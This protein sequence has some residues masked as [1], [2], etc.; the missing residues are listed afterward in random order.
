M[1]LLKELFPVELPVVFEVFLGEDERFVVILQKES[2]FIYLFVEADKIAVGKTMGGIIANH[3]IPPVFMLYLQLDAETY[4]LSFIMG[5]PMSSS[6]ISVQAHDKLFCPF[7]H[8]I[9]TITSSLCLVKHL[10]PS[11]PS[12]LC[13]SSPLGEG[14]SLF[15]AR[16]NRKEIE[17]L[18][19]I[20]SYLYPG[21]AGIGVIICKMIGLAIDPEPGKFKNEEERQNFKKLREEIIRSMRFALKLWFKYQEKIKDFKDISID[22]GIQEQLLKVVED[23]HKIIR[24]LAQKHV[25]QEDGLGA[26]RV[27]MIGGII[28]GAQGSIKLSLDVR[29]KYQ[30]AGLAVLLSYATLVMINLCLAREYNYHQKDNNTIRKAFQIALAS[31]E[32]ILVSSPVINRRPQEK[33]AHSRRRTSEIADTASPVEELIV[34][35]ILYTIILKPLSEEL[36]Q[37]SDLKNISTL[38]TRKVFVQLRKVQGSSPIT[39]I[40]KYIQDKEAEVRLHLEQ[41]GLADVSGMDIV[42]LWP[43]KKRLDIVNKRTGNERV[44]DGVGVMFRKDADRM[45]NYKNGD[46]LNDFMRTFNLA[47]EEDL[48]DLLQ[49]TGEKGIEVPYR[50]ESNAL[51]HYYLFP[52][53]SDDKKLHIMSLRIDSLGQVQS[54]KRLDADIFLN[55]ILTKLSGYG[56]EDVKPVAEQIFSYIKREQGDERRWKIGYLEADKVFILIDAAAD[57]KSIFSLMPRN[58]VKVALKDFENRRDY[59]VTS[60]FNLIVKQDAFNK[61]QVYIVSFPFGHDGKGY[62]AALESVSDQNEQAADPGRLGVGREPIDGEKLLPVLSFNVKDDAFLKKPEPVEIERAPEEH[63]EVEISPVDKRP[64]R[65][66]QGQFILRWENDPLLKFF[67]GGN[68]PEDLAIQVDRFGYTSG[69]CIFVDSRE[70]LFL[71]SYQEVR[72][73]KVIQEAV[74]F[75][76]GSGGVVFWFL[77]PDGTKVFPLVGLVLADSKGNLF[78]R[79]E[80]KKIP[81]NLWEW[82]D[83]EIPR[84]KD[85]NNQKLIHWLITGKNKPGKDGIRLKAS[86]HTPSFYAIGGKVIRISSLPAGLAGTEMIKEAIDFGNGVRGV[87]LVGEKDGRPY[88]VSYILFR[89]GTFLNKPEKVGA[90][91]VKREGGK[92]KEDKSIEHSKEDTDAAGKKTKPTNDE[93]RKERLALI[94]K[95]HRKLILEPREEI[96][97]DFEDDDFE[98][99]SE[100]NSHGWTIGSSPLNILFVVKNIERDTIMKRFVQAHYPATSHLL[101]GDEKAETAASALGESPLIAKEIEQFIG[102]YAKALKE[103]NLNEFLKKTLEPVK[104]RDIQGIQIVFKSLA[105]VLTRLKEERGLNIKLPPGMNTTYFNLSNLNNLKDYDTFDGPARLARDLQI[106]HLLGF[107]HINLRGSGNIAPAPIYWLLKGLGM[108]KIRV[109]MISWPNVLTLHYHIQ[110]II[111]D[112]SLVYEYYGDENQVR[113]YKEVFGERI[114]KLPLYGL[115]FGLAQE[116][117]Q[118]LGWSE[119]NLFYQEVAKTEIQELDNTFGGDDGILSASPVES[120]KYTIRL[121]KKLKKFFYG[122]VGIAD[123]G[124]QGSPG[125][126][127]MIGDRQDAAHVLFFHY[128]MRPITSDG[129][130]SFLKSLYH[131]L[132]GDIG[133]KLR[134]L[135]RNFI[136]DFLFMSGLF[137]F[138]AF[139]QNLKTSDNGILNILFS[140]FKSFALTDASWNSRTLSNKPAIL[141]TFY[142]NLISHLFQPPS[143]TKNTLSFSKSQGKYAGLIF[144]AV[145]PV[146]QKWLLSLFSPYLSYL[147]HY[148][149][150]V[151]SMIFVYPREGPPGRGWFLAEGR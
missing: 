143:I 93:R 40:D 127:P 49:G 144:T 149:C 134:H 139:I 128:N 57:K 61:K 7:A 12:S 118:R 17:T 51:N 100:G 103:G 145:S 84:S 87:R 78:K 64:K 132:S 2:G 116:V 19:V 82:R 71:S 126:D 94:K 138:G 58:D 31:L 54:F 23:W 101:K 88:E 133:R 60:V 68:K 83:K 24:P 50:T 113:F 34:P 99:D 44:V 28:K 4:Y 148:G 46:I 140:L 39:D 115:Y 119:I 25:G 14:E 102:D 6:A 111:K 16:L 86:G 36:I 67:K 48:W 89:D 18:K 77:K 105:E 79:T 21:V 47:D 81:L 32:N 74:R 38:R 131:I 75:P 137:S 108:K 80:I 8:N 35:F 55:Y 95:R 53:Y 20:I 110:R 29:L 22:K 72:G 96:E 52:M 27:A 135:N 129:P 76:D 5:M 120:M 13:V 98:D 65:Y 10:G 130:P 30:Y 15:P 73:G 59:L 37:R 90:G 122:N 97:S 141:I 112:P 104:H 147:S 151:G 123:K 62:T 91:L 26:N 43:R 92:G 3:G 66:T 106:A 150:V 146:G 85:L 109:Y 107:I 11:A 136:E 56:P 125:K 70:K 117:R 41:L 9:L 63:K 124:A 45:R 69:N 1:C 42:R 33:E 142:Y 121:F 114:G